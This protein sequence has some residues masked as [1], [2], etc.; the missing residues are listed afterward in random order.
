M[1][2]IIL[3]PVSD[4]DARSICEQYQGDIVFTK[5]PNKKS[6]LDAFSEKTKLEKEGVLIYT[7]ND[8]ETLLGECGLT[9]NCNSLSDIMDEF[10]DEQ[11]F[12][13]TSEFDMDN[14]F[15]GYFSVFVK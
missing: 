2:Y 14:Y 10:N 6:V 5:K 13:Q 11:I 1:F 15:M 7:I 4:N 8:F 9:L 12:A 3:I